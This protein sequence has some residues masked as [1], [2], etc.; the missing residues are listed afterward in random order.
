MGSC[1]RDGL[2]CSGHAPAKCSIL[3]DSFSSSPLCGKPD[4]IIAEGRRKKKLFRAGL[5]IVGICSYPGLDRG[6]AVAGIS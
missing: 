6:L 3:D 2:F 1:F 4:D 5:R